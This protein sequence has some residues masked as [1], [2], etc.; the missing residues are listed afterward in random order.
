MMSSVVGEQSRNWESEEVL[1]I[2][3]TSQKAPST[4][5]VRVPQREISSLARSL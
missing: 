4:W 1:L 5:E 3:T 2:L